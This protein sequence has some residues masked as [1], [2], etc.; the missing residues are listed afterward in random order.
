MA[1]RGKATENINVIN[2]AFKDEG[3]NLS[4]RGATPQGFMVS[5]GTTRAPRMRCKQGQNQGSK[6]EVYRSGRQPNN[7]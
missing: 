2:M 7:P 5:R 1:F 3:L 6:A 4:P